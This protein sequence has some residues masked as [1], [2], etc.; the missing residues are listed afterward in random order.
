MQEKSSQ[1]VENEEKPQPKKLKMSEGATFVDGRYIGTC[2][3][4]RSFME[5]DNEAGLLV[6]GRKSEYLLSNEDLIEI[7]HDYGRMLVEDFFANSEKEM[8]SEDQFVVKQGRVYRNARAVVS[9]IMIYLEAIGSKNAPK[10]GIELLDQAMKQAHR[11]NSNYTFLEL[12]DALL[13]IAQQEVDVDL[14]DLAKSEVTSLTPDKRQG[15]VV[16]FFYKFARTLE[17]D[18]SNQEEIEKKVFPVFPFMDELMFAY[19]DKKSS[20]F[21]DALLSAC[22]DY[23]K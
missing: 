1:K 21:G 11:V 19:K 13:K 8:L 15:A 2:P 12:K 23:Q 6:V 7:P 18:A 9:S 14:D 20:Q 16:G 3:P 22:R 17:F 4:E 10:G 5:Y